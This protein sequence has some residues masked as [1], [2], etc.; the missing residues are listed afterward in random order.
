MLQ[1]VGVINIVKCIWICT[2]NF[3]RSGKTAK[4]FTVIHVIPCCNGKLLY[5]IFTAGTVLGQETVHS[6]LR[7]GSCILP[8]MILAF[9][10]FLLLLFF[11][12]PEAVIIHSK[13]PL[14]AG[15]SVFRRTLPEKHAV[16]TLSAQ[17][18]HFAPAFSQ[19]EFPYRGSTLRQAG[20]GERI[21]Y[22]FHCSITG[23]IPEYRIPAA[24]FGQM[25]EQAVQHHMQVQAR[26]KTLTFQKTCCKI[27][28]VIIKRFSVGG[29][30]YRDLFPR[31]GN[32]GTQRPAQ[33]RQSQAKLCPAGEQNILS[34]G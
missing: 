4:K 30:T 26:R 2:E 31:Q 6:S 11:Q 10:A 23:Q 15:N 33:I 18:L 25:T 5:H 28:S 12:I 24:A 14:K 3:P 13:K 21:N 17:N 32:K 22:T 19:K 29:G 20:I 8:V 16:D 34:D 7:A 1:P 27:R 9:A